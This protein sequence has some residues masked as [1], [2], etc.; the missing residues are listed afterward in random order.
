MNNMNTIKFYNIVW[1]TE[2]P[3]FYDLPSEMIFEVEPTVDIDTEG[4]DMLSDEMGFCVKS[5]DFE[6]ISIPEDLEELLQFCGETTEDVLTTEQDEDYE[7]ELTTLTARGEYCY[8]TLEDIL[9]DRNHPKFDQVAYAILYL[10]GYDA[11]NRP[12]DYIMTKVDEIL[13]D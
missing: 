5:F 8:N 10:T 9:N 11:H 7:T 6:P 12:A 4:A 3:S 1:D 13:Y 2:D